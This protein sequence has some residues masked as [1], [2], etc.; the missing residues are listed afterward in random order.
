MTEQIRWDALDALRGV[1]VMAMLLNLNPGA[2]EH[3][4]GWLVHA[5]WEGGTVI[6]MVAPAFLF[7]IG[8]ALPLSLKRRFA[9]EPARDQFSPTLPGACWP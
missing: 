2:W 6:D 7:C 3:A 1:S 5:R 4:Y 9:A 8:A